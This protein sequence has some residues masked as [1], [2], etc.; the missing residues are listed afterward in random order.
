MPPRCR[1]GPLPPDL[2]GRLEQAIGAVHFLRLIA[3]NGTVFELFRILQYATPAFRTALLDQLKEATALQLV[4]KTIAAGR[5]IGTLHL[6]MREL[7]DEAPGQTPGALWRRASS[8]TVCLVALL[9]M[10]AERRCAAAF[11]GMQH[12]LLPHGQRFGMRPA[13]LLAMGAHNIGDFQRRPHEG[14]RALRL[15]IK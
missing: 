12:P 9:E 8:I 11:D 5:S 13:K 15:G 4:D 10:P 3:A 1:F 2:L 7:G 6:A 14:D